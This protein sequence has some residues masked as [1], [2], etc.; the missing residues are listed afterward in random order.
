MK[1]YCSMR[2]CRGVLLGLALSALIALGG[3]QAQAGPIIL[4]VDLGG[5]VI[6][7][8]TSVA[9]D[10]SVSA[11]LLALNTALAAH[12]SAYQ[13]TSLSA[14]SNFTGAST[15]F[16]Q[17]N[18]QLN[19]SGTGTTAVSLSIDTTQTGFLSPVGPGGQ[20]LSTLAGDSSTTTT[21]TNNY[22]SDYQGTMSSATLTYTPP[23]VF[24]GTA[25]L[26]SVGTV[27][28]GFELSNHFV[29]T[30]AKTAGASEGI[31]GTATLTAAVPE[32]ASLVMMLSSLPVPF[33]VMG[34]RRRNRKVRTA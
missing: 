30:L 16:L 6:F 7:T 33:V 9:P 34:L 26:L 25:P 29:I 19:T 12:G 5:T 28:S 14:T 1:E 15:A 20:L 21:G 4:T 10:Q 27:P 2:K 24:S 18:A 31:T 13:F 17:T 8:A 3:N 11:N 32:P 23:G 22:T